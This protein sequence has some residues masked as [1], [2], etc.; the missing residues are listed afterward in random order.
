MMYGALATLMREFRDPVG[1]GWLIT[2]FLLVGAV[3]AALCSRLGDL[4]G[5]KRLVLLMLACATAGSLI[6]AFATSLPWLIAGRAVQGFSAAL[7][8]LCIGLVREHL[9]APRVPVAHR[10]AGGDGELQRGRR[11]PAR[12]LGG[13]PRRL[14]LDL[15]VL[16]RPR[17]RSR[18][19]AW[20]WCCRR[21][22]G[23]PRPENSTCSAACCSRRRSPRLLWAITRLK[24]SGLHDPL[25]LALVAVG[26][27]TLVLW[28][29]R[30][31]WHPEPDDRRA[32][33]R[34][35]PDRPDDAADGAVRPG[36]LATD[37]D[38]PADRAAAGVDRHRPR[39]Q[40][41]AGRRA[42]DSGHLRRPRRCAMERPHGG[43]ARRP[44][45]GARRRAARLRRLDRLRAVARR[46]VDAGRL[47]VLHH[48]RRL[49]P[50]C[51]DAQP[52]RRGGAARAHQ[53]DQ[54]HVA[55]RAH[56]RHGHRHAA[57]DGAARQ[58]DRQ[59]SRARAGV[60]SE[61]RGLRAGVRLHHRLRGG[62]HR[63][64]LRIAAPARARPQRCRAP[65]AAASLQSHRP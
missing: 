4:Y 31:W 65:G 26:L 24:G 38:D 8:P 64:G 32:P 18:W 3:S 29:R 55:R 16:G 14:A 36:H 20:R 43:E 2:A 33:L 27:V 22:R 56:R 15:L 11:H 47:L 53:R 60:A 23:R 40:R 17:E 48:V 19:C 51:G 63:G 52:R 13:G 35:A 1:T 50:V 49:D 7:L 41:D 6:A 25:T 30:E 62:L 61:P 34:R 21:R 58:L 39:S 42:E 37:A 28:L 57:R 12:R 9:P 10:L 44:P 46:G 5:R 54:R 59:R 45:R